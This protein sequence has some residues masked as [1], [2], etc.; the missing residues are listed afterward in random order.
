MNPNNKRIAKNTLLLYVRMGVTMLISLYTSR[1]ILNVLG[2]EDFGIY[3]VVGGLVA[4]FSIVSGSLSS[5][6]SRYL[7]V[8]LGRNDQEKLNKVFSTAINI[9]T[10]LAIIVLILAETVGVWF[11]NTQMNIPPE[12]MY[13]ANWVLQCSI[14]SFMVG[15]ISVPYNASL[16]SHEHMKTFAYV[17]IAEA[18]IKLG[19]V[20]LLVISPIDKLITNALL[21]LFLTIG[22]RIFYGFYCKKHFEEA[23]YRFVYDKPL[24]KEMFSFAGWSFMGSSATLLCTQGINILLNLFFGPAVNAARGVSSQ[25]LNAITGLADNF[26]KA[27]SPQIVKTYA[28][29]NFDN[30]I[31]LIFLSNRISFYLILL[32]ALPTFL[33][34]NFILTVWL[35]FVPEHTVL[36]TRLTLVLMLSDVMS[37]SFIH[38]FN[39]SGKIKK[40]HLIISILLIINFPVSYLFLKLGFFPEVTM[41]IAIIISQISLFTKLY[42]LRKSINFNVKEYILKIYLTCLAVVVVSALIPLFIL[43]LM[44]EKWIRLLI[45]VGVSM[46]SVL[47]S[48]Y[49]IGSSF[50]ERQFIIKKIRDIRSKILNRRL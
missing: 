36:F 49:Y 41:L 31:R 25:L 39:A 29:G 9:Y 27:I 4:M 38:I 24:L 19:I 5:S 44:D 22:T 50:T 8:E 28:A 42:L 45:V 21:F 10:V 7:T 35:K 33:E 1:V 34:T 3:N 32:I 14:L 18:V 2:V 20:Y 26:G 16:I 13:A 46:L 6:V 30:S 37:G 23:R 12:R 43:Q 15:L 47:L 48:I 11:L 17:G 40:Y